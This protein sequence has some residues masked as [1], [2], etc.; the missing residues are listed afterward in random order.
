MLKRLLVISFL[1][2]IFLSVGPSFA[3]QRSSVVIS[4][5]I[6]SRALLDAP[7]CHAP[8]IAQTSSGLVVA[9][10]GGSWEGNADTKIF[11][12][13]KGF[14]SKDWSSPQMV[15]Q[16]RDKDGP[17]ASWNP[18]LFSQTNGP[19]FL[20]YKIGKA[21][22]SWQGMFIF[23]LDQGQTWSPPHR[24]PDG[25]IGPAKNKP[26][27]LDKG[28]VL[29]PS[30]AESFDSWRIFIESIRPHS[31]DDFLLRA[32]W[33]VT[34]P[35]NDRAL[36]VIQPTL[37]DFGGGDILLLSRHKQPNPFLPQSIMEA[38]SMDDG[39]TWSQLK[40]TDLPNPNSGIDAVVL[41][42]GRCVL[43]YNPTRLKR[44]PLDVAISNDQGKTW[45]PLLRLENGFGEY[46][47][48]SVIQSADGMIHIVYTWQRRK[49][50]HVVLDPRLI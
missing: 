11:L 21:P 17:R 40:L 39:H 28:V 34:G 22:S 42:D 20:F 10:F 50:K 16:G 14:G 26:V 6:F 4:E 5:F 43:V 29:F 46:S 25:I 7:F 23:S 30:S 13:R 41:K 47:Y 31:P 8:T 3:G 9:W 27:E 15:A 1:G 19:L 33:S 2:I 49:I 18:V 12:S 24:L 38:R 32:N 35:L 37:L 44:T 36:M 48:P 45:R